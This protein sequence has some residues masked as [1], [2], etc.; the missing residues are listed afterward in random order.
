MRDVLLAV[1]V[2]PAVATAWASALEAA[3]KTFGITTP[4][5][6]AA[7]VA[8][9]AH[10][11]ARFT[12]LQENFGWRDAVR[13]DATFSAVK[14]IDDAKALIQA[15]PAAIANRVYAGRNGNGPEGSG[16][17][18]RFI[19]RGCLQLTGRANYA[20][21]AAALKRPYTEQPALLLQPGDAALASAWWWKEHGCNALADAGDIGRITRVINGSAMAGAEERAALYGKALKA[22]GAT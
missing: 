17:G 15:G 14:G 1:G 11:S 12:R 7:F 22:L 4:R 18:A 3:A 9:C 5:R 8:Q 20:A 6:I 19:G 21:A 10:E 13:L 2:T 16:D